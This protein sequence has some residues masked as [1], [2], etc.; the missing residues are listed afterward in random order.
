MI[1]ISVCYILIHPQMCF[2][3]FLFCFVMQ[4]NVKCETLG[5]CIPQTTVHPQIYMAELLLFL[6]VVIFCFVVFGCRQKSN[7]N[8]I[9]VVEQRIQVY[10]YIHIQVYTL[11]MMLYFFGNLLTAGINEMEKKI[12]LN[13]SAV[14]KDVTSIH[15][16]PVL[17]MWILYSEACNTH[18]TVYMCIV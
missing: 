14:N 16:S 7:V 18:S 17:D 3:L 12:T 4:T 2:V 5:R 9:K 13:R 1:S 15:P 10:M 11:D 6:V 8:T